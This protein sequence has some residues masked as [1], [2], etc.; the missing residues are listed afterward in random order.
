DTVDHLERILNDH[1][2]V[3][4]VQIQFNYLDYGSEDVQSGKLYEVC[5]K[6]N[7]PVFVMEPVKGGKLAMLP[8]NVKKIFDELGSDDSYASYAVRFALNYPNNVLVLSGVSNVEQMKDNCVS[9]KDP[10]P[11]TSEE[12]HVIKKAVAAFKN[13]KLVDCT[14]CSYCVSHNECPKNINIPQV[15]SIYNDA[16]IFDG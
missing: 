2:E 13:L 4:F 5:K 16:K 6:Y 1:P 11:L 9:M 8:D 3:E 10:K 14:G 12:E 15:F 7:K